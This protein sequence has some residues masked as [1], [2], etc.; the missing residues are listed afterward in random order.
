MFFIFL[1]D[2]LNKFI[3]CHLSETDQQAASETSERR[4]SEENDDLLEER[5]SGIYEDI[6]DDRRLSNGHVSILDEDEPGNILVNYKDSSSIHYQRISLENPRTWPRRASALPQKDKGPL[7]V[8]KSC[9]DVPNGKADTFEHVYDKTTT[10]EQEPEPFYSTL[11]RRNSEEEEQPRPRWF[12][13]RDSPEDGSFAGTFYSIEAE[14][15]TA[16]KDFSTRGRCSADAD[17]EG[18]YL[19]VLDTTGDKGPLKVPKSCGDLTDGKTNTFEHTEDKTPSVEQ[20]PE[21]FHGTLV[22]RNSG[23][24]EQPRPRWFMLRDSPEDG[25][26]AGTFYSTEAEKST[27]L[28]DFNTEGRCSAD[29]DS[30]GD[31]LTVLD[32]TGDK[33]PLKVLKSCSDLADGKT[34][35]FEHT[36]DRASSPEQ[37]PEPFH[38]TLVRRNSGKEEQPLP[39]WFMLRDSPED[40]SFAGTFYSTEAEKS[41]ALKDFSTGGRCSANADGEGDYLTVLD[42]SREH[43]GRMTFDGSAVLSRFS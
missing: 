41:T 42:S 36:D 38:S 2:E 27:A 33:G 17:G 30:E 25:S 24:E 4:P 14:K 19:T 29:A 5:I 28:K 3:L 20:G 8:F 39:R 9:G 13:L 40:G 31:Y 34:N 37:K 6:V 23:K 11:V 18:D 26:F 21:P 32:S 16:L 12:M 35:T 1:D 10:A 15:S 22:R 43:E 7:K